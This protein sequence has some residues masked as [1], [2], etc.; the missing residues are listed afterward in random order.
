MCDK[1]Y[2][3]QTRGM[4]IRLDCC[5]KYLCIECIRT[6]MY[7]PFCIHSPKIY[8]LKHQMVTDCALFNRS[9]PKKI[10]ESFD[11]LKSFQQ[12]CIS[13]YPYPK[14]KYVDWCS[15]CVIHFI[16]LHYELKRQMDVFESSFRYLLQPLQTDGVVSLKARNSKTVSVYETGNGIANR[17][18]ANQGAIPIPQKLVFPKSPSTAQNDLKWVVSFRNSSIFD[19]VQ[20]S[21]DK[22]LSITLTTPLT[23]PLASPQPSTS[24]ESKH[25]TQSSWNL[26]LIPLNEYIEQMACISTLMYVA[27]NTTTRKNYIQCCL[28]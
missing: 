6:A 27:R 10:R 19:W 28:T 25:Q 22:P 13:R 15:N 9:T 8:Q 17:T 12:I 7:C 4:K 2:C 3:T 20:I 14:S 18:G 21:H 1:P 23:R 11:F 5:Q 16:H 24:G 26:G